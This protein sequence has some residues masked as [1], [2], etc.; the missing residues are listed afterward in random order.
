[1]GDGIGRDAAPVGGDRPPRIPVPDL[2]E[3]TGY[4]Q[5]VI[6]FAPVG[7][8]GP[9]GQEVRGH[10][11]RL[12][13]VP[14]P[15]PASASASATPARTVDLRVWHP[16]SV[17]LRMDERE[18]NLVRELELADP[19]DARFAVRDCYGNVLRFS[20]DPRPLLR[21]GGRL[22]AR[23]D[24]VRVGVS[25]WRRRRLEAR[26]VAAFRSFYEQLPDRRDVFYMFFSRGLL[27]WVRKSMSFVPPETNLVL[28]GSDL[29]EQEREWVRTSVP[30]PFHHVDLRIDD[31][32]AWDMLFQVNRHP[33]G[34]LDSDCLV[35]EGGLFAEMS[36]LPSGASMNC[37]W[38]WESGHGFPLA[39]TFFLFV[40]GD[41]ITEVRRQGL[42]PS[43]YAHDYSWQRIRVPGRRC[44]ARRPSAPQ[45][46]R[47]RTL[48]PT[49]AAGRPA[50]PYG[51]GYYDTMVMFQLLA[52]T[53]GYQINQ[54]RQLEGFGHLRSRPVQD[55][56]SD[57]LVH[58]GGVSRA[59]PLD[60]HNA[61][62][63]DSA[64]RLRYLLAEF[65]VLSQSADTLPAEYRERQADLAQRLAAAGI[66][67]ETGRR[68]LTEH[69]VEV[70]GLSAARAQAVVG[71]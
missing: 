31:Q 54:V 6:G 17:R 30:R 8:A 64:V 28:L 14:V 7:P 43:P 4:Y 9:G 65:V 36:R 62:F 60:D 47:L 58:V 61:Y 38:S 45:V 66:E 1:M 46:R 23:Y 16:R 42:R 70:R 12:R 5:D 33:F 11:V 29:P 51:M 10:G 22:A 25:E 19:R 56:S 13:L 2:V 67:A 39:N 48:M 69:L 63:H 41:A 40:N 52:R 15:V 20:S 32:V 34:W 68:L 49:D 37:T 24:D 35:L 53:C 57:E 26:H 21:A 50:T 71:H 3:A 27:H 59:D 44:Y 55:E 18:A